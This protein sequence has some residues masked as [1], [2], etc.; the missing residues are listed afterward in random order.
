MGAVAGG[1]RTERRSDRTFWQVSI[2]V[3]VIGG[4]LSGAIGAALQSA[5]LWLLGS[6]MPYSGIDLLLRSLAT[7]C[8]GFWLSPIVRQGWALAGVALGGV[9]A[10]MVWLFPVDAHSLLPFHW[11]ALTVMPAGLGGDVPSNYL[12]INCLLNFW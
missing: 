6:I 10:V 1:G 12:R 9:S 11:S 5:A 4:M 7:L 2:T 8:V 3:G